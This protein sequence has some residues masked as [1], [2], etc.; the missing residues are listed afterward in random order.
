MQELLEQFVTVADEVGRLQRGGSPESDV[1]RGFCEEGHYG[2]RSRP[3]GTRQGIYAVAPSGR[4]LA[5]VNTTVKKRMVAMLREALARWQQ[6]SPAERTLDPERATALAATRRFED[7]YPEDGLVLAEYV[8]DLEAKDVKARDWRASAW[9]ED[10]V[11]FTKHEARGFAPVNLTVGHVH[12]VPERL[13][14]R[15]AR[16]HLVDVARGQTPAFRSNH[17]ERAVLRSEVIRIEDGRVHLELRGET[18]TRQRGRWVVLHRGG[19]KEAHERGVR[20]RLRGQA[21]WD[22]KS[23]RF[24]EFRLLA[25]GER[26][27]ATQ[28]NGRPPTLEPTPIAFAFVLAPADHPR[29]APAFFWHYVLRNGPREK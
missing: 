7:K 5:S 10:Q 21:V 17:V 9:N 23:E 8:R 20:T 3:T 11:W 19:E 25:R 13:V 2:G 14:S 22:T 1:F 27:G 29:V 4:F 26:W 18:A 28:Y 24:E 16:L 12:D 6:L 15:L